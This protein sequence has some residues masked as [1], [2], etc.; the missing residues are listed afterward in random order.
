MAGTKGRHWKVKDTS[1]MHHPSWLKGT[2][3]L[4]KPNSGSWKK[5]MK[6]W[7]LEH[8]KKLKRRMK[9][10]NG[11]LVLNAHYVFCK[12]HNIERIPKGCVIHHQD[13]NSLNDNIDNLILMTDKLHRRYHLEISKLK[14]GRN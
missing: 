4:I 6:A 8:G 11:K 3:G 12:Y 5:G 1:R 7:N 10:F 9:K 13:H 14:Q 2:K